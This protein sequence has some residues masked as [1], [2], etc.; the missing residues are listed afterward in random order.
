MIDA[1]PAVRDVTTPEFAVIIPEIFRS[2]GSLELLKVPLLILV[3]LIPVISVPNPEKEYPVIIPVRLIDDG[4]L[5]LFKVPL[6]ILVALIPVI[7]V[8]NPEK[9]YPVI[10]PIVLK[11]DAVKIPVVFTFPESAS[12]ENPFPVRGSFPTCNE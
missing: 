1:I 11:F 3:A 10:L 2:V 9:L 7:S 6:L 5:E 12:T 4:S 8:P